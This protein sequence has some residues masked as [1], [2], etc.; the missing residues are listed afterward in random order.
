MTAS[1]SGL[2]VLVVEDEAMI[3]ML[4]ED[5][6]AD[7]GCVMLGPAA[8]PADALALID[9]AAIDAAILDVNLG[10]A[11]TMSIAGTL[12][13]RDIPFLFATGYG[14]SGIDEAFK[15]QPVLTKPFRD[16]EL[17]NALHGL[18]TV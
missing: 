14:T 17:R 2:R 18:M 12:R 13:A 5:M 1:L 15:D 3:A 16:A 9:E 10:G 7:L 6:L 11:R 4:I 8:D